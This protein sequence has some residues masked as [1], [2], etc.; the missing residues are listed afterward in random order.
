[1]WVLLPISLLC[2]VLLLLEAIMVEA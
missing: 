2:F 1:M